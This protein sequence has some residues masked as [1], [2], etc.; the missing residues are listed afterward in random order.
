M[1]KRLYRLRDGRLPWAARPRSFVEPDAYDNIDAARIEAAITSR[2]KAI[3][4]VHLYRADLRH[5]CDC[6]ISQNVIVSDRRGGL[7]AEPRQHLFGGRQAGTF[8]NDRVF[9][10]LSDQ[11]AGRFRRRGRG[12]DRRRGA[13]A[14]DSGPIRNYGSQKS[15]TINEVVGVEQPPGYELQAGLL[16]VRLRHLNEMNEERQ[17][18]AAR[19][20]RG[21]HEPAGLPP[22]ASARRR[23]ATWHQYVVHCPARDRLAA[24]L[25]E[26]GVGTEHPLPH[27]A[28]PEQGVPKASDITRAISPSRSGMP[29][30]C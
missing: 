3:L 28:A 30:R 27:P 4:A 17:K 7:R 14:A 20:T 25:K 9:Q 11:G 2:C 1:R 5:G 6:R 15:S 8:G 24:F 10:L 19:Y 13:G 18:I 26:N 21:I 16:R 22:A 12:R 29:A 23:T